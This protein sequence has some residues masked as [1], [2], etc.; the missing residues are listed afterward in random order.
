MG[1]LWLPK[2][3][4]LKD[5]EEEWMTKALL[6]D[7]N[8]ET[9]IGVKALE[10]EEVAPNTRAVA[11][12]DALN[13][14]MKRETVLTPLSSFV[15]FRKRRMQRNPSDLERTHPR[16][17]RHFFALGLYLYWYCCVLR[18][19]EMLFFGRWKTHGA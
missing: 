11:R 7:C 9:A 8:D 14:M 17:K 13:F 2:D 10:K 18:A 6:R 16:A 4:V 3:G 5:E 1:I 15:A 19:D 12:A